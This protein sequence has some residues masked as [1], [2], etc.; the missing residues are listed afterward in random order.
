M[1]KWCITYLLTYNLNNPS[2]NFDLFVEKKKLNIQNLIK[3]VLQLLQVFES[4][5]G[6]LSPSSF[7]NFALPY[8][9]QI[10]SRVK[11]G[12]TQQGLPPVPMVTMF[13]PHNTEIFFPCMTFNPLD[14]IP[15]Q[16]LYWVTEIHTDNKFVQVSKYK[17]LNYDE[18]EIFQPYMYH[19][20][21][22]SCHVHATL[23]WDARHSGTGRTSSSVA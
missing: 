7:A 14:Q 12:L 21:S 6:I 1:F 20:S 11:D 10:A 22:S 15:R 8:L 2:L 4:H 5:A 16:A 19:S 23:V 17:S 3:I 9:E 13:K 18:N